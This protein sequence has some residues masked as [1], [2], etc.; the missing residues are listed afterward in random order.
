[1]NIIDVA[2]NKNDLLQG[3]LKISCPKCNEVYF[4]VFDRLYILVY[5][6]CYDCT[7]EPNDEVN[8]ENIMALL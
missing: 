5:E 2:K 7:Q 3:N 4:S 1:M 8:S 6:I